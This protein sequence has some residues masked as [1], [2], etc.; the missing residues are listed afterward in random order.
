MGDTQ[1]MGC[2]GQRTTTEGLQETVRVGGTHM[3]GCVGQRVTT[4]GL[5]EIGKVGRHVTRV[6]G[7][8]IGG[9][10]RLTAA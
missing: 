6:V 10:A 8:M 1:M 5:Q 2:V 7:R 3:M 9:R 4:E